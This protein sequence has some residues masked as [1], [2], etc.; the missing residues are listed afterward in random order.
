MDDDASSIARRAARVRA[1][2]VRA[3]RRPLRARGD[4]DEVEHHRSR[5]GHRFRVR[6][7]VRREVGLRDQ[8][9]RREHDRVRGEL[10]RPRRHRGC[11]GQRE[12]GAEREALRVRF[13]TRLRQGCGGGCHGAVF[14]RSRAPPQHGHGER[15]LPIRPRSRCELH[16][17][18]TFPVVTLHPRFPF[19]V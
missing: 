7:E 6:S 8:A 18:R 15:L 14:K 17:L 19:N 16:S 1:R 11:H 5:R 12:G 10:D 2:A 3:R 13:R 9:H 4:R